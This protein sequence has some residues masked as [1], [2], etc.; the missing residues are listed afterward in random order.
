MRTDHFDLIVIGT[1]P[2]AST[3]AKKCRA[4]KGSGG[5]KN[6]AVVEAREFGGTCALRGCNPKKVYTNAANLLDAARGAKG[7]LV[8]YDRLQID[9]QQ[10]LAFKREF[11]QPVLEGSRESF[12][13]QGIKTFKGA[14]SFCGPT[15]M[16]VGEQ[17]L[18]A[19]RIFVGVGARPRP[20]QVVGAEHAIVSDDFLELSSIPKRVVFIGGGYIS[21]EFAC[22]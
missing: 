16:Q 20:L 17:R 10:L 1:G 12:D 5:E 8:D 9:W 22:V 2:S 6:V 21:M 13:E 19:E 15:Q 14:A 4:S 7:K 18:S 11:T 3:V